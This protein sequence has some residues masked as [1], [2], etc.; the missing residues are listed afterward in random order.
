MQT[1][2][3]YPAVMSTFFCER[4]FICFLF[5]VNLFC[6][7]HNTLVLSWDRNTVAVVAA[8]E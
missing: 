2:D 8:C 4:I 3:Y 1:G 7:K 6:S 5:I